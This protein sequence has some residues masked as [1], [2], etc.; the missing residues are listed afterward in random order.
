MHV[1]IPPIPPIPPIN[2]NMS[3]LEN[4][5][6]EGMKNFTPLNSEEMEKI[7]RD[8]QKA[9]AEAQKSLSD[10]QRDSNDSDQPKQPKLPE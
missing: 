6:H 10:A 3:D 7:K 2:L 1:T 8:T 5:I 9:M 4:S